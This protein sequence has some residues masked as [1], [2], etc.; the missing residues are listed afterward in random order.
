MIVLLSSKH[1]Y[2]F[3]DTWY[4]K[5]T[6]SVCMP[7]DRADWIPKG[8]LTH[9]LTLTILETRFLRA[10]LVEVLRFLGALRTLTLRGS[11][12]L[13][14]RMVGEAIVLSCSRK[15]TGLML[16]GSSLRV[17]SVM[18]GTGWMGILSLWSQ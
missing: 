18:S 17:E 12:R 6:D 3:A 1:G 8:L 14:M 13:W 10:D 11:F 7:I 4:Y 5:T 16:G 15:D 2:Y 9:S